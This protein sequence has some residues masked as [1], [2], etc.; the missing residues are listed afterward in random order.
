M[1]TFDPGFPEMSVAGKS[2]GDSSDPTEVPII[3]VGEYAKQG[4]GGGVKR[5]GDIGT[6]MYDMW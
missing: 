2:E 3:G 1:G 6:S 5:S 4:V